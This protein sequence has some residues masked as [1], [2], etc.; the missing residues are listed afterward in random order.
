MRI[1]IDRYETGVDKIVSTEKDVDAMRLVL[2]ELQ[3]K[4]KKSTRAN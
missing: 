4:L 3:P 1:Q 2:F